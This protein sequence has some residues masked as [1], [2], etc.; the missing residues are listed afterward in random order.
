MAELTRKEP[1]QQASGHEQVVGAGVEAL[2]AEHVGSHLI[3]DSEHR[4][5]KR[6]DGRHGKRSTR[7]KRVVATC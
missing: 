6:V 3:D 4:Q 2:V 1:M 7:T 5:A